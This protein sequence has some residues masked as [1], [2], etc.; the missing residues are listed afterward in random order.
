LRRRACCA[1]A[2]VDPVITVLAPVVHLRQPLTRPNSDRQPR[3]CADG[4]H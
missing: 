4:D 1:P 3:G 2:P